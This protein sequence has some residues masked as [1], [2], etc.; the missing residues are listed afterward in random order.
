ML[1]T[2]LKTCAYI[3]IYMLCRS[4]HRDILDLHARLGSLK[5][6]TTLINE[7][8]FITDT[9]QVFDLVYEKV[10][11]CEKFIHSNTFVDKAQLGKIDELFT[12][13]ERLLE[14]DEI[15]VPTTQMT[16]A[17]NTSH[18]LWV[19]FQRITLK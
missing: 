17:V 18:H 15:T 8:K 1:L 10:E 5:T 3:I 6:Y 7:L 16:V 19:S 14:E 12:N 11:Q 13:L 2:N 9:E 4:S